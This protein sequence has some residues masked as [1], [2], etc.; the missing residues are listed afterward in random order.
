MRGNGRGATSRARFLPKRIEP[1]PRGRSPVRQ[2][3]RSASSTGSRKGALCFEA[4]AASTSLPIVLYNI[5]HRTGVSI[6]NDTIRQ[7]APIENIVGLKDCSGDCHQS[8]ELLLDPP[9]GF[10]IL[11]GEDAYLCSTLA[12]GGDGGILASA[13]WATESFVD[14]CRVAQNND[15]R[16]ARRIWAELARVVPLFFEEPNPAPMKYLLQRSGTIASGEVRLPLVAPSRALAERLDA[17]L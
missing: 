3:A 7:L 15:F 17:L 2:T 10:S 1:Q 12:L 8:M 11:T 14:V 9:E 16:E 6:D 4:L 5:P 13:H